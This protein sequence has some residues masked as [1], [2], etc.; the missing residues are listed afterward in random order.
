[1]YIFYIF[2]IMKNGMGAGDMAQFVKCLP[3][4]HENLGEKGPLY[5]VGG[6]VN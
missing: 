3:T 6:N 5:I 2:K 1:M 4:R